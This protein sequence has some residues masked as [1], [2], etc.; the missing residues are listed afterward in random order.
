MF[1]DCCNTLSKIIHSYII[2]R[3][4]SSDKFQEDD[5][6]RCVRIDSYIARHNIFGKEL[7][8]TT[9]GKPE[10]F[11]FV[12]TCKNSARSNFLYDVFLII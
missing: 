10:V 2:T 6:Y 12:T 7:Q 8:H 4:F 3:I 9:Y 11:L 5:S 1:V